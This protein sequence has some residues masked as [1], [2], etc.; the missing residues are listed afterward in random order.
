MF[1]CWTRI[2]NGVNGRLKVFMTP[3]DPD[4]FSQDMGSEYV[5]PTEQEARTLSQYGY[6]TREID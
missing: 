1:D 6:F 2:I 3:S 4:T 5:L